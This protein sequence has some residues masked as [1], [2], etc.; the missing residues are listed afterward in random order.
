MSEVLLFITLGGV[1]LLLNKF[2]KDT[3][4]HK[5]NTFFIFICLF[6]FKK[7]E[8]KKGKKKKQVLI[9]FCVFTHLIFSKKSRPKFSTYYYYRL[10][11]ITS[12]IRIGNS[13]DFN[14][15]WTDDAATMVIPP[16]D[17]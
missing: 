16:F 11:A 10:Q 13:R 7:K 3:I 6:F 5:Y 4:K 15:L 1:C 2:K 9:T 8:N 12:V 14:P 17:K